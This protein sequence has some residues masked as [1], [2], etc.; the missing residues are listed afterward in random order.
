MM[1]HD[2]K[3]ALLTQGE[4]DF[5]LGKI[6]VSPDY[7]RQIRS[8]ISRKVKT[9]FDLELPLIQNLGVTISSHTVTTGCHTKIAQTGRAVEQAS[10]LNN[11]MQEKKE[12]LG[13]IRT[14]DLGFTK[15][16]LCQ[17]ELLGRSFS[18][19]LASLL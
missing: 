3:P 8:R 9:F 1:H 14:H 6:Q 19:T 13:G 10:L 5:L 18:M 2:V 12:A 16:S 11:E 7:A 15:P 17:A 4:L